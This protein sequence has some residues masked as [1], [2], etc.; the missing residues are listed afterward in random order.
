MTR[1]DL[2]RRGASTPVRSASATPS[3]VWSRSRPLARS[4]AGPPGTRGASCRPELRAYR[5]DAAALDL[6]LKLAAARSTSAPSP[7]ASTASA[8]ACW[9]RPC[10]SRSASTAASPP[11]RRSSLSPVDWAGRRAYMVA[12]RRHRRHAHRQHRADRSAAVRSAGDGI[13]MAGEIA[14]RRRRVSWLWVALVV[15]LAGNAFVVG[16]FVSDRLNYRNRGDSGPR[17]VKMETA[18]AARPPV[19]RLGRYDRGVARRLEAGHH[20]PHQQAEDAARRTRRARRGAGAR[21]R[22]DRRSF[23]RDPPR[24]RRDAG[25]DP[26]AHL[27]RRARP[28]GCRSAHRLRRPRSRTDGQ[29]PRR[30]ASAKQS[31][32]AAAPAGVSVA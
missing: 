1:R 15:S 2:E 20:R 27:R 31:A 12:G 18:L 21:P 4:G 9:R 8:P 22:R 19:A 11:R 28:A 14:P 24:G 26:V 16:A 29:P 30:S 13:L 23:A 6:R 7:A 32:S 10:R 17:A 3:T 25:A 5:D